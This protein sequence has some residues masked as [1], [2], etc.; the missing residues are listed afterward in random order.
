LIQARIRC[1]DPVGE[2]WQSRFRGWVGDWNYDFDPS[3][4]VNRLT[5]ELID[6]FEMLGAIEMLPGYF[7]DDPAS[8][9][10]PRPD[11]AGQ[12]WYDAATMDARILQALNDSL[13]AGAADNWAVV[14]SGNVSL[15]PTTYTPGE[16]PLEVVTDAVDAEWPGVANAFTDRFGRL[17]AHGREARFDPA[18]VLAGPGV[19]DVWDWHHW[20]VGD[21]DAV[22][23]DLGS[24]AQI[25]EFAFNRGLSKII[26][27]A[28][29]SP[30]WVRSGS[31]YVLYGDDQN[32]GQIV[33]E[34]AS[35]DDRGIRSWSAQNLQ[36]DYG[37][38]PLPDGTPGLA[39]TKRFATYYVTNYATPHDRV[40]TA[41]FRSIRADA[42]GAAV[43][44]Q[45]LT[46]VDIS[47]QVDVLVA[48]PGGGS[49]DRS[50][51]VE[52]VHE[53]VQPLNPDMDDVTV[54]LDLSPKALFDDTSMF[55]S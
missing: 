30:Q 54:S 21:G 55:P 37:L 17:A 43:T 45:L 51:Y 24:V 5:L 44:W 34:P 28:L 11:A 22:N 4:Q 26:N 8:A 42:P 47:D 49:F 31:S 38:K 50:C 52:G 33:R 14:F 18:G 35:I 12:V 36:T 3:Q 10:P 25:H 48:S 9:T 1:W 53:T 27:S 15:V 19:A 29:A 40:T 16:T 20:H 32:D 13:P 46:R 23:A 7:G 2:T 6:I 41:G 39:E